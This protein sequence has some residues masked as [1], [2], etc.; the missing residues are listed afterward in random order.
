M[1]NPAILTM[2]KGHCHSH[3]TMPT[4]FSGTDDSELRD[5]APN[6]NI[7]VSLIVNNRNENCAKIAVL[8]NEVT[9]TPAY[10][11]KRD[12]KF[13]DQDGNEVAK[14][15]TKEVEVVKTEQKAIYAYKCEIEYPSTV[16]DTLTARFRQLSEKLRKKQE[17]AEKNRPNY[18]RNEYPQGSYEGYSRNKS[19]GWNQPELFNTGGQ[20][21]K[22]SGREERN[23]RGKGRTLVIP[24]GI[25]GKK[26]L[27]YINNNEPSTPKY[28][29]TPSLY[30]KLPK[31][32]KRKIYEMLSKMLKLDPFS[33]E[34]LPNI[35]NS[36]NHSFYPGTERTALMR[37]AANSY[38]DD[39][40]DRMKSFYAMTYIEDG[41]KL[42]H[43]NRIMAIS[44]EILSTFDTHFPELVENLVEAIKVTLHRD[45]GNTIDE[46]KLFL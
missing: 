21:N 30:A 12:I 2:K 33:T 23:E 18:S 40:A 22:T 20:A 17:L 31:E 35:M 29:G 13:R 45:H 26:L 11:V 42:E 37:T 16:G 6:H 34:N 46:Q 4:F 10:T 41:K 38:Y 25:N 36:L 5:N 15:F 8:V 3:N 43:Y 44:I 19:E 24:P 1:E 9:E 28:Q 27:E 7:Y 32:E 39:L 14:T